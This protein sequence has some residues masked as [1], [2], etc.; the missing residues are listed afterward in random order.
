MAYPNQETRI[1]EL[2]GRVVHYR[3]VR[4]RRR[5]IG[6]RIDTDGLT[7]SAPL[8]EPY[9]HLDRVIAERGRWVVEKL[10]QMEARRLPERRWRS[11]EHLLLLGDELELVLYRTH[12]RAEPLR[13][14]SHLYVGLPDPEDAT[15]VAERVGAWYRRLAHAHFTER[16]R[17]LAPRLPVAIPPFR[18]SEAKTTWGVCTP[19]G[20]LRLSWRLIKAPRE[21][22]DYVIAH[23]LAHLIHM[24][25]SRQ[26]W[27]TVERI[28]P[29]WRAHKQA[30]ERDGHKYH[31][32]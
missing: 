3:L 4:R 12:T 17:A 13:T 7:V 20:R 21:Q 28:Y 16:I 31:S 18:L 1:I 6:L 19:E 5:S 23:E 25:H 32:F 30:L 26:F 22:I 10:A 11:G 9:H 2:A 15:G 8:R 24:N 14:A 27:Q 29:D